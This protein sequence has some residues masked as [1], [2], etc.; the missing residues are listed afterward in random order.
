MV[1]ARCVSPISKLIYQSTHNPHMRFYLSRSK[2]HSVQK[3]SIL[4]VSRIPS[5]I[6]TTI[7]YTPETRIHIWIVWKW[8]SKR[9]QR[10]R[11]SAFFLFWLNY[12]DYA[13]TESTGFTWNFL[14]HSLCVCSFYWLKCHFFFCSLAYNLSLAPPAAVPLADSPAN[15]TNFQFIYSFHF[16]H[17]EINLLY[18]FWN[19]QHSHVVCMLFLAFWPFQNDLRMVAIARIN[20]AFALFRMQINSQN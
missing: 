7:M 5:E 20:R 10:K 13:H 14:H 4:C 19:F 3:S 16:V 9:R 17:L 2:Q 11:T 8:K 12:L 15:W 18:T 6:T 1:L